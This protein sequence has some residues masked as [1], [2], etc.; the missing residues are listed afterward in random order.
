MVLMMIMQTPIRRC[1]ASSCCHFSCCCSCVSLLQTDHP[2][3]TQNGVHSSQR[4]P[5]LPPAA[6]LSEQGSRSANTTAAGTTTTTITT[7]GHVQPAHG[8]A[9][10][11]VSPQTA[12]I[13]TRAPRA[14]PKAP[15]QIEERL[16]EATAHEAVG[17]G[18]AARRRVRQQLE[19]ADG[20]VAQVVVDGARPE[21]G[22]RV[23]HVQRRPA[24]EKL[25]HHHEQHFDDAFFVR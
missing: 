1:I 7:A 15:E 8:T 20:R 9:I 22:H 24:D 13:V 6:V 11:T 10:S 17:D 3:R 19:E 18:V 21:Q 4:L 23:D 2:V 14:R 16:P 25:Q 5:F 12:A